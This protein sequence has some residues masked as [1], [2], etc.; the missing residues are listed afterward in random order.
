MAIKRSEPASGSSAS[1]TGLLASWRAGN[2]DAR[3]EL[4]PVV[5][6]ELHRLAERNLRRE[7]TDHTLQ[8][9]A[10]V[11]EAYLRL[12]GAE[13]PWEDRAHFFAVAS[14]VMRQILVDYARAK[15]RKK[16]GA[17]FARVTLDESL[18]AS[19][20]RASDLVALDEA[21][22]L[23]AKQDER[24][25]RVVELHYFGGLGY[26]EVARVLD[27]SVATVNRDLRMAK[28]WLYSKMR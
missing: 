6:D 9:T 10:L 25:A 2:K 3:T 24:K 8:A 13:V 26:E 14:R 19:P 22:E 17:D 27:V 15:G 4:I 21:L 12:V 1:V 16:R 20:Q 18:A 28:A 23:L 5:Y 11:N 7:R